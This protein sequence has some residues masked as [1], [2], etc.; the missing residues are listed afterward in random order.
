MKVTR[1]CTGADGQ[2]HF[3]EIEA[4]IGKLQPG[5]GIIFCHA[6]PGDFHDCIGRL[7]VGL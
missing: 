5:D 4:E 1:V 2:S 6:P 7:D 3:D